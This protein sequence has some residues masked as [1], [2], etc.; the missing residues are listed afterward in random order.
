LTN[1]VSLF[2]SAFKSSEHYYCGIGVMPNGSYE[3][4]AWIKDHSS[5]KPQPKKYPFQIIGGQEVVTN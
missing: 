4:A 1:L 2:E 3:F 5:S